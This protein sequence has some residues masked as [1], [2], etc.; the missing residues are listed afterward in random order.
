MVSCITS[1]GCVVGLCLSSSS[2]LTYVYFSL[3]SRHVFGEATFAAN[4]MANWART[5]WVRRHFMDTQGLPIGLSGIIHLDAQN[6]LH[7]M[8]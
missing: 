8:R 6:V 7:V 4:F 2:S 1:H 3:Y 5:H